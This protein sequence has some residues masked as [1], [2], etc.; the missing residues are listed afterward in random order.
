MAGIKSTLEMVL[1]RAERMGK[2]SNRELRDQ[3]A[4]REG[5]Q[6]AAS[7]LAGRCQSLLDVLGQRDLDSQLVMMKGVI[8]VLLRNITLPRSGAANDSPRAMQ[9]L[10]ELGGNHSDLV[11]VFAEVKRIIDRYSEHKNQIRQQLE[12]AFRQ[13]L[14][15]AEEQQGAGGA[16]MASIDPSRHPGF[17]EEWQR[18]QEQLNS[19]Y[20]QALEQHKSLAVQALDR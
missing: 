12:S 3:E 7:F 19:Q 4:A 16:A 10:L 15:Q 1:E 14:Q 2:A 13:Q 9:G 11:A 5:K 17:N 20:G 8:E 18:L 6:L